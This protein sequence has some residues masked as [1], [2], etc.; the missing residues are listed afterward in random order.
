MNCRYINCNCNIKTQGLIFALYYIISIAAIIIIM[1]LLNTTQMTTYFNPEGLLVPLDVKLNPI[2]MSRTCDSLEC[3]ISNDLLTKNGVAYVAYNPSS[4]N[5]INI[6]LL[7]GNN[8]L[9]FQ[10]CVGLIWV[11]FMINIILFLMFK[12]DSS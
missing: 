1:T 8:I 2:Y 3:V 5:Q 7:Y 12:S 4:L 11:S 6:M 9:L 10:I